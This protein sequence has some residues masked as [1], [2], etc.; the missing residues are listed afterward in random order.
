MCLRPQ[1][2]GIRGAV[3]MLLL[4][5]ACGVR[6]GLLVFFG[7]AAATETGRVGLRSGTPATFI[8]SSRGGDTW[9]GQAERSEILKI[10]ADDA[11][12]PH[13]HRH[14]PK[15]LFSS[16]LYPDQIR[17]LKKKPHL[18]SH[19]NYKCSQE[20]RQTTVRRE[21]RNKRRTFWAT[22]PESKKWFLCVDRQPGWLANR[23][24]GN[25]AAF[26]N[27]SVFH[28]YTSQPVL[29][30]FKKKFFSESPHLSGAVLKISAFMAWS[31]IFCRLKGR[32][33][34]KNDIL[35]NVF[36]CVDVTW[37]FLFPSE[38]YSNS[39]KPQNWEI[40]SFSAADDAPTLTSFG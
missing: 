34:F 19:D 17:A 31:A 28:A 9:L 6:T 26:C 4:F 7:S 32:S 11:L 2:H 10:H 8:T 16:L 40:S 36:I 21:A 5:S 24:H 37:D 38:C 20:V 29:K 12:R 15:L 1:S 3:V 13:P 18:R 39:M 27:I 35:K 23:L 30:S 25:T 14:F 33:A 22:V